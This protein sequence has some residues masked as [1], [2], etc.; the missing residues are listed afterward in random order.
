MEINQAGRSVR[1]TC[2]NSLDVP[3]M[4]LIRQLPVA[5][6]AVPPKFRRERSWSIGRSLLFAC[7]LSLLVGGL[8][9]AAYYQWGRANL[10]TEETT[11]D[12]LPED[13]KSIDA[14]TIGQAWDTW[15]EVRNEPIG[16]YTPPAFITYRYISAF[17]L[18]RVIRGLV[19]AGLGLLV[20]LSACVAGFVMGPRAR[21]TTHRPT[22]PNR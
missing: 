17:W 21:H 14:W 20:L 8:V 15:R 2:G 6:A 19:I 4:R 9:M 12:V 11:W 3:A 18:T 1:C 10:D 22:A 16:P 7:G 13:L 5:D